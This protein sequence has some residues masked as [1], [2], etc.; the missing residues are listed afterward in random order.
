MRLYHLPLQLTEDLGQNRPNCKFLRMP[1]CQHI[2]TARTV[3]ISRRIPLVPRWL[4]VNS[5]A[6]RPWLNLQVASWFLCG[7]V[8]FRQTPTVINHSPVSPM[9]IT[10]FGQISVTSYW[11]GADA[12]LGPGSSVPCVAEDAGLEHKECGQVDAGPGTK[13]CDGIQRL[14][15]PSLSSIGQLRLLATGVLH[16]RMT[17]VCNQ[18]RKRKWSP[19]VS[20]TFWD[21]W[22]NQRT[23]EIV[24][25]AKQKGPSNEFWKTVNP[26]W[27]NPQGTQSL[28]PAEPVAACPS[29]RPH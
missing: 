12:V 27:M 19:V 25:F 6:K 15:T 8:Q 24:T 2:V 23:F 10:T 28:S 11:Q 17:H 22:R 13:A 16:M 3:S 7:F 1:N 5:P 18:I 9:E 29:P 14:P 20:L 26:G 21:F 4:L